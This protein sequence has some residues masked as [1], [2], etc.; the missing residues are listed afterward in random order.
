MN[1]FPWE[2]DRLPWWVQKIYHEGLE[3]ERPWVT[4]P[5]LERPYDPLDEST[6]A[7]ETETA[8]TTYES[9]SVALA[10]MGFTIQ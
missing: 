9:S 8:W 2:W 6:G 5:A 10:Q 1:L 7:F 4:M 3:R